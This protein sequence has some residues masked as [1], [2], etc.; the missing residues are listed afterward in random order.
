MPKSR[1]TQNWVKAFRKAIKQTCPVGW[2][3][4]ND[5]GRVRVQIGKRGDIQSINLPYSWS[6]E[7]WI[8]AYKRIEVAANIYLEHHQNIDIKNAFQIA[9]S[10][11]NK[12]ELN[13]EEAINEFRSYK[14]RVKDSTWK[15]KYK[16]VLDLVLKALSG[17]NKPINGPQLC[18][19]ALDQW[20]K[21][22]SQRRH[23]RLALY[24]LL[25]YCVHRLDFP[26][27]WLPPVMSDD[28]IVT[29]TKRIG[30]PLT[31]SQI[32]RLI[33]GLPN[34][35]IGCR[36]RF[37]IQLMAV[38]GLRPEDLR[39]IY[40]K[41]NGEEI[42]TDYRKSKGGRK[43]ETTDPRKLMPIWV[44]DT[45]GTPVNW[46]YTL[47]DRVAAGESLPPLGKDGRAGGAIGTYL[48]RQTIWQT[49]KAEAKQEREVLTPYSF[50]HRFAY[51]GH[52]RTQEDGMYRSP[53]KIAEAMGHEYETHLLSYA[54][55]NTKD[56][57]K[58]FDR[59]PMNP[60]ALLPLPS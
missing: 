27:L 23:M 55:F 35:D 1:V 5:R 31:D 38:Y 45:D 14:T 3:M 43:G 2:T 46:N 10:A 53:K 21:G 22:T 40:T 33:E 4:I 56:L 50:R 51:Y 41:K 30:Y 58:S 19:V 24:G 6:E 17:K 20:D 29:K 11:S 16:P 59:Q 52:H 7:D 12:I 9:A 25:N 13:W 32:I 37:G 26:T 47:K 42:W 15:S 8:D 57:E 60:R 36:W 44:L 48:K 54:R 18:E 49:L 34:N 28:E 39:E